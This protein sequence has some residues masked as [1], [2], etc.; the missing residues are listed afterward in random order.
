LAAV[1]TVDGPALRDVATLCER[2]RGLLARVDVDEVTLDVRAIVAPSAATVD[3]LARVQLSA[4]RAGGAI[5]LR[6]ADEELRGLLAFAG[7]DAVLPCGAGYDS[8]CSGTPNNG[9]RSGSTK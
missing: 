5:R 3:A 9:K 7:L 2:V 6:N 1:L 8:G 4:R